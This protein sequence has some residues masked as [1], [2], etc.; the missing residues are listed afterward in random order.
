MKLS[1]VLA[2]AVRAAVAKVVAA[3]NHAT[4]RTTS[5]EAQAEV[6]SRAITAELSDNYLGASTNHQELADAVRYQV[7]AFG[8]LLDEH[9]LWSVVNGEETLWDY[10][11]FGDGL[12]AALVSVLADTSIAT[13]ADVAHIGAGPHSDSV[14]AG[15]E[16]AAH[17]AWTG[18]EGS[19]R[20]YFAGDYS[21]EEYDGPDGPYED[22]SWAALAH[23][24]TDV[25]GVSDD[26]ASA[27]TPGASEDSHAASDVTTASTLSTFTEGT[28]R[29]YFASDYALSDYNA[30]DNSHEDAYLTAHAT[31]T[32]DAHVP[33]DASTASTLS[34]F[35]EGTLRTYFASDYAL[36][37]YNAYE[38]SQSDD[39]AAVLAAGAADAATTTDAASSAI[40]KSATDAAVVYESLAVV[41]A[42]SATDTATT[43]DAAAAA[44]TYPAWTDSPSFADATVAGTLSV[45]AEGTTRTYFASD[46]DLGDYNAPDNS[47]EDAYAAT[48]SASTADT[49]TSSDAAAADLTYPAWADSA[50]PVDDLALALTVAAQDSASTDDAASAEIQNYALD[51]SYFLG[52]YA[53]T[54]Y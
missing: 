41:T 51:P 6:I 9:G 48:S 34:V 2:L 13:D 37:D 18:N 49:S 47:H 7:L 1:V 29:T 24:R 38:N 39:Y 44:L 4:A 52:D 54:A 33:F 11:T 21:L 10:Q 50:V 16:Q 28:T 36:D 26:T 8:A 45:F 53:T 15:D 27:H 25:I 35:A 5:A 19:T 12:V 32:S 43:T 42:T 23:G 22:Y 3:P 17:T 46:Y 40:T 14:T 30:P 20:S 31:G